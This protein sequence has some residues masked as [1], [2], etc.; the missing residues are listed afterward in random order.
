MIDRLFD[1]TRLQ[2]LGVFDIAA[3]LIL[4]IFGAALRPVYRSLER[5]AKL[6]LLLFPLL[7]QGSLL[8]GQ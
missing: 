3:I 1:L 6:A 7:I 5:V 4:M 8:L 2:L